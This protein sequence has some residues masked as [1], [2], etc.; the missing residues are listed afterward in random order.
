[1]LVAGAEIGGVFGRAA[2]IAPFDAAAGVAFDFAV[3]QAERSVQFQAVERLPVGGKLGAV[4]VDFVGVADHD[5][6]RAEIKRQLHVFILVEKDVTA[7]RQPFV[8]AA[9]AGKPFEIGN[10]FGFVDIGLDRPAEGDAGAA[11]VVAARG[12]D[13][14]VELIVWPVGDFGFGQEHGLAF[15][16]I[17]MQSTAA[18]VALVTFMLDAAGQRQPPLRGKTDVGFGKQGGDAVF[19]VKAVVA[20][21]GA[22]VH[23]FVLRAAEEIQPG[24]AFQAA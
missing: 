8:G 15:V 3:Q 9:P 14:G 13:A 20:A 17:Q 4:G 18:A 11:G 19:V 6:V 7:E 22:D 10:V 5:R 16:Q 1:M 24:Q 12:F 23:P 21:D 2:E